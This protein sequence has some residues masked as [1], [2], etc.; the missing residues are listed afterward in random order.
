M[1][2]R[3]YN[4]PILISIISYY[5][6][7]I[8]PE[9]RTDRPD[10]RIYFE[11]NLK[12]IIIGYLLSILLL[13]LNG[14]RI[15]NTIIP[16]HFYQPEKFPFKE[17]PFEAS[18]Y[19]FLQLHKWKDHLPQNKR[20]FDKG[21]IASFDDPEYIRTFILQTC[22]GETVHFLLGVF[23]FIFVL[24]SLFAEDSRTCF[25]ILVGLSSIYLI[26][27]FPFIWIQRFNRPRLIQ[28]EKAIRRKLARQ[29]AAIKQSAST[30]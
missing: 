14:A 28:L 4:S 13:G 8:N 7:P 16:L 19:K 29:N 26:S 10:S 18:V 5:N 21:K 22:R 30:E 9:S 15:I 23:G 17:Q 6:S 24:Y 1:N 3:I 2:P 12:I 20:D 25:R 27:Q 11:E